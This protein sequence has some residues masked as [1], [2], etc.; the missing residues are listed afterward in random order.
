MD[1]GLYLHIPFC[2]RKCI[3]CDFYSL[4]TVK[5][6]IP[7]RLR[8]PVPEQAEFLNAL[9]VELKQLPANFQPVTVFVGGG[10][11]TEL[12]DADLRRLFALLH[13]HLDLS[14]VAEWTCES[15]PGTLTRDK[16]FILREAGVNRISM[17]VQSFDPANLEFLGRI[18]GPDDVP[19]S[20]ALLRDAGFDNINLD[21]I[22]G[23]PGSSLAKT[24]ADAQQLIALAPEH[25]SCYA[26]T[27]EEGTPL[28]DMKGK[29]Y[30]REVDDDAEL[31]QYRV[32]R[33][34][35]A[36]AGYAQYELSN[37]ARDG[38][39][40]RHNLL[41]WGNGAYI[42]C[43]PSAHS[44]WNGKRFSN[45]RH[46]RRYNQLLLA[47]ASACDF[48]EQLEPEAKARETLVMWLRRL[49]GVPR[50]TFLAATGH[51]YWTLCG[52]QIQSLIDDGM[53]VFEKGSL[54]L[55]DAGLF[56]SDGIFADL[57]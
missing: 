54:R 39:T 11:P 40:C 45:V 15:N 4:E 13:Q 48:E 2:V 19:T 9:E 41:Y 27:F 5:G 37:F 51:D 16:A 52:P 50:K 22:Y 1:T 55:T 3:Y 53:L 23:I 7:D 34:T 21:L 44:H 35:L 47:G 46:L 10:T 24:E 18:H 33:A 26:L 57:V 43:G 17:G 32:I 12:A 6:P 29:G 31:E 20:Y 56:V 28:M 8:R 25:A 38:Q 30:V 36:K 14:Q 42:G 49:E